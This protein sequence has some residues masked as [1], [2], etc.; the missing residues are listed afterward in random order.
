M[1]QVD[2][3]S[4]KLYFKNP[5]NIYFECD[6]DICITPEPGLLLMWPSWLTHGSGEEKNMS[7]ERIVV[8]SNTFFQKGDNA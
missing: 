8:S 1:V 4:S 7:A 2:E 6:E 5:N 3:K